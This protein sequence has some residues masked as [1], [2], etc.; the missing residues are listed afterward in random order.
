MCYRIG[1][2]RFADGAAAGDKRNAN[3]S[4]RRELGV[5]LDGPLHSPCTWFCYVVVVAANLPNDPRGQASGR[6][7]RGVSNG[8]VLAP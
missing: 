2:D 4:D 8:A 3:R 1:V 5:E 6:N 7:M